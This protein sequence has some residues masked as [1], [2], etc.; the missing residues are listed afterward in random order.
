MDTVG[1]VLITREDESN[2]LSSS[3]AIENLER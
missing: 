1:A 2:G 3:A